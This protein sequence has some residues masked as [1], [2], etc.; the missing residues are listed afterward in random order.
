MAKA[1]ANDKSKSKTITIGSVSIR[2]QGRKWYA[3]YR[4]IKG[5]KQVERSL[6]VTNV[7]AARIKAGKIS[8]LI[9]RGRWEE[10]DQAHA[11]ARLKFADMVDLFWDNYTR[12]GPST[13]E[14]FKHMVGLLKTTFG[15]TPLIGLNRRQIEGWLRKRV[16]SGEIT[17]STANRYLSILGP[18]FTMALDYG[19]ITASPIQGIKRWRETQQIPEALTIEQARQLVALAPDYARPTIIMALDTGLRRSELRR[20]TWDDVDFAAGT[21]RARPVEGA[22]L[23]HGRLLY[24][25]PRVRELLSTLERTGPN[26]LPSSDFKKLLYRL[27]RDIGVEGLHFHQMRHT[28][29]TILLEQGIPLEEIQTWMGHRSILT[30]R[31]YAKTRPER[32]LNVAEALGQVNR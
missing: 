32:M 8:E 7:Q 10:I 15:D 18:I 19:Y 25:T 13:R 4:P 3:R 2:K 1:K 29:A 28:C 27:G 16:D 23:F 20:L 21:I 9:E 12:W 26:I 5:A 14:G 17:A 30:T 22:K 11:G 31:R 24:M 6:E